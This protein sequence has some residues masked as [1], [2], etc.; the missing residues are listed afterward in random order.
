MDNVAGRNQD[1]VDNFS[2]TLPLACYRLRFSMPEGRELPVYA[3]SAWRGVLGRALK[4][5]VCVARGT[6][7]EQCLLLHSCVYPY[8]FETPPPPASEKMRRYNAT[9]HPF[10]LV[11]DENQAEQATYAL[12]LTLF[13]RGNRYLPYFIHAFGR[14]GER[15]IGRKRQPFHLLEVQQCEDLFQDQ[16]RTIFRPDEKLNSQPEQMPSIPPL[17][18]V[19]EIHFQTPLRLK[20]EGHNVRPQDFSFADL[21]GNLL[22]R[23]SMLTYF[24]TETPLE[25]D[26]AGLMAKAR[27]VKFRQVDLYWKDWTR[28]S[29][30]QQTTMQ[31]GGLLGTATLHG[32]EIIPFWPYLW[33]G[34]WVHAGKNTSMGLGHYELKFTASLPERTSKSC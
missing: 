17:P 30:R 7:C 15:G 11:L 31:M 2:L 3:G 24:H 13:G 4:Q 27:T 1:R 32:E 19:V 23:F 18:G 28:Y 34:Q 22:R 8:V 14:A 25:A 29:S 26:F 5:T 33:L 16:W 6:P 9:P 20:R 10:V 12:G 21:F